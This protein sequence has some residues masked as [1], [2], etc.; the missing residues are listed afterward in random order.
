MSKFTDKAYVE[1]LMAAKDKD[2]LTDFLN[3]NI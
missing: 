3:K 1:G 2:E